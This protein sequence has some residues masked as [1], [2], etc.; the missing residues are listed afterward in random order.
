MSDKELIQFKI[1]LSSSSNLKKPKFL[2]KIN[3]EV[4]CES[5]ITTDSNV[6][7]YFEFQIELKEGN[8]FLNIEFLNKSSDDTKLDEAGN[9]IEDL[10]L[11]I[12]S[13]EID[14]IDIGFLRYTHS[15]YN[16]IYPDNYLNDQQKEIKAV[17]NCINLGW[18]GTWQLPF[19]SPV[20]IWLL[21][22]L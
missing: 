2:I 17:K 7:E 12:D 13:I 19:T 8:H 15:I 1:G 10:L 16:P 21:E 4:K 20:Y 9:I 22:N 6:T 18:N 14:E 11:N 3:D 5:I